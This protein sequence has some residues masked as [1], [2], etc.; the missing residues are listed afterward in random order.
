MRKVLKIGEKEYSLKS[1]AYTQFKY[2]NDTGRKMLDDIQEIAKIGELSEDKQVSKIE[3]LID[4]LLRMAYI[5]IEEADSSQ[6]T[7]YEDFLKGIDGIFDNIEWINEVISLASSPFSR[8]I[9][10]SSPSKQ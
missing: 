9:Q 3:D 2:R 4:L 1:S 7:T 6:V 5:M 10:T 8:G